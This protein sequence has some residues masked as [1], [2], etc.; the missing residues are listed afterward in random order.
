MKSI[1]FK[2]APDW[3]VVADKTV[4]QTDLCSDAMIAQLSKRKTGK[5]IG[6][7]M[8]LIRRY[9]NMLG[10][11][12]KETQQCCAVGRQDFFSCQQF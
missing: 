9:H 5:S 3:E 1:N 8:K 6:Y 11:N 7:K 12:S 10:D 2:H 4:L